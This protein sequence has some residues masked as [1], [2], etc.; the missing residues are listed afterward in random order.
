MSRVVHF[1]IMA[2]NPERAIKFY[3]KVFG[4][5]I[6]KWKGPQDYWMITTGPDS[7]PGINGGLAKRKK[8]VEGNSIIAYQCIIQVNTID[9]YI[10]KI[11]A[12]GGSIVSDK[13][14]IK[15]IGWTA[16]CKDTEGNIFG[17]FQS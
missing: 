8:P 14:H 5:K 13:I 15:G 4:W 17:I 9:K 2:D 7:E 11:K 3:S 6:K 12:N 1:E 16:Y 10:N